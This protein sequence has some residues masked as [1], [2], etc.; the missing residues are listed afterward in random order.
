MRLIAKPLIEAVAQTLALF[1]GSFGAW[2][3]YFVKSTFRAHA[4]FNRHLTLHR[5]DISPE[6]RPRRGG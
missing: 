1:F 2:V 3:L 5:N 6:E 4:T